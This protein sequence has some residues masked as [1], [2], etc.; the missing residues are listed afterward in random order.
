MKKLIK[1]L[2]LRR[3]KVDLPPSSRI[4]SE[5]VVQHREKI[6]AG[7]RRFKYPIQY[8][9]HRLVY[10]AIAIS[11][12]AVIV[13]LV[14]GW[15]QLYI[16]QNTSEFMY[17]VTTVLPVPVANVDGQPVLYSDYL[18][19]YR[20]SVFFSEQKQQLSQKTEDGKRQLDYLKQ[21]SMQEVISDAYA[22]KLSKNLGISVSE[23]EVDDV[24]KNQRQLIDGEIS[25]QSYDASTLDSF[26]WTPTQNRYYIKKGILRSKVAYEID[27][28]AQNASNT[29]ITE[30]KTNPSIDLKT[31]SATL[32]SGK[33][34]KAIYGASGWVPANNW[35]G[36]LSN[37]AVKL[38]KLEFSPIIKS[39]KG[40]GYYIVRLLD[41]N[42]DHVN[43]EYINIQLTNFIK[44]LE[45]VEKDGKVS[46]YIS[47]PEAN[48]TK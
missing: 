8:A 23:K 47:M 6:L 16:N 27:K 43:Y 19:V 24:I 39:N 28:D 11:V 36:G 14:I 3:K 35:D 22:L 17:R 18:M 48:G 2:R 9:R 7:G 10:N 4:T 13:A 34:V 31:L 12:I 46:K 30:I 45:K 26:G 40:D 1:K 21:Q 20:S 25:Q 32:S 37:E 41:S 42:E 44:S 15:W 5:T 33:S 29:A 38:K